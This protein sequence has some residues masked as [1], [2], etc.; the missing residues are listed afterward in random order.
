MGVKPA[1]NLEEKELLQRPGP[2]QY[3]PKPVTL[4]NSPSLK[5]GTSTREDLDFKKQN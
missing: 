4:R 5:I 1:V 3:D 2:G